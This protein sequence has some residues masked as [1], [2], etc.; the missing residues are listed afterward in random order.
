M[1]QVKSAFEEYSHWKS[2]EA[3]LEEEIKNPKKETKKHREFLERLR[4]DP[5]YQHSVARKELGYVES[6]KSAS[7][8]VSE[9]TEKP[10]E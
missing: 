3:V 9:N 10:I 5:N 8:S 2:R 4:R 6:L 7:L 1:T